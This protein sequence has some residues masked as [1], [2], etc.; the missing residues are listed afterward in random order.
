MVGF[1]LGLFI[2]WIFLAVQFYTGWGDLSSLIMASLTIIPWAF[3]LAEKISFSGYA[4]AS[5]IISTFL[6]PWI[7]TLPSRIK[8]DLENITEMRRTITGSRPIENGNQVPS[9]I[10][11]KRR[12]RRHRQ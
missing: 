3:Y 11:R 10:Y 2:M 1:H 6:V 4:I 12:K 9:F 7:A 5:I 8:R